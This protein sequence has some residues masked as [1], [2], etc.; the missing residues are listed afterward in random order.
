MS[1][2]DRAAEGANST[3]STYM[4]IL[5]K[6]RHL[7]ADRSREAKLN[8]RLNGEQILIVTSQPAAL[9]ALAHNQARLCREAEPG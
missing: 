9:R 6:L 3:A 7:F 2:A 4:L 5:H 8:P 1:L